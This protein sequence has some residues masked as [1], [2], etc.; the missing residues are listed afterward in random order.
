MRQQVIIGITPDCRETD[1]RR[2][3]DSTQDQP[4]TE[5][6]LRKFCES[7]LSQIML[8]VIGVVAACTAIAQ[9][10]RIV[11]IPIKVAGAGETNRIDAT[12]EVFDMPQSAFSFY[13]TP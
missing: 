3:Q 7:F 2:D 11:H 10:I 12:V 5:A 6:D 4:S 13:R 8:P 9:S 1:S